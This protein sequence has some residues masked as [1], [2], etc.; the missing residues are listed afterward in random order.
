MVNNARKL[1]NPFSTGGGGSHFEA[2]VQAAFVALMLAGGF[3]PCL[4]NWPISK[5][6]LQGKFAGYE[7][8]DLVVFTEMAGS[9]Q[10]CKMLA[11]IKHSIHVTENDKVFGEVIQAAWSDF[12]NPRLFTRDKDVIALITGPLS[13]TDIQDVRTILEWARHSDSAEEFIEKVDLANFSSQSKR[14][15]LQAFRI[16]LQNANSGTPVSN[17]VLFEFLKHFYLLGYDLDV[18]SGVT[19]S[20][21]HSLIGQYAVENVAALWTQLVDEVQSAN[22]NAGT[23][24]RESLPEALRDM[25]ALPTY[26]V[27]PDDFSIVQPP[28]TKPDWNQSQYAAALASTNLIGAWSEDSDADRDVIFHITNED[29]DEWVLKIR[30]ILQQPDSPLSL[31]EQKWHIVDRLELWQALGSRL[32]DQNLDNF[33]DVAVSTLRERDPQFDLPT[34]ERYMALVRGKALAHSLELRQGMAETLAILANEND[35]LVHCSPNK[36][37]NIARSAVREIFEEADWI[38]WGSLDALLSTLAEAAPNEFLDAVDHALQQSPCPFDELFAQ[39]DSGIMGRNYLTGLLW[40]LEALAWEETYLVR[41]CVILGELATHDPGGNWGNRP[42]TSLT[43]ILLPWLPQTTSSFDRRKAAVQALI[44]EFP[45]AAWRLLLSLLPN[46]HQTSFYT[47]KPSWRH[48]IP[49]DWRDGVTGQE[50]WQQVDFYAEQAVLLAT[51]SLDKLDEL[52]KH[53]ENLPHTSLDLALDYLSSQTIVDLPEDRRLPLWANLMEV[54]GRHRQF[55]TADWAMSSDTVS[56][57]EDVADRLAPINPLNLHRRLFG[58]REFDLYEKNVNLE[59][60]QRKLAERRVQ[61]VQD[62]LEYGGIDAVTHFV[63]SVESPHLVGYSL[64]QLADNELDD[65]LLPGLLE[66]ANRSLQHFIGGYVWSRHLSQGWD[67][68]DGLNKSQWSIKQISEFLSY[69]PFTGETWTRATAWLGDSEAEYWSKAVVNPY[70]ADCDLTLAIDKLIQYARPRAAIACLYSSIHNH[71]PLDQ[72][73]S[74]EA[75][76]AVLSS[77]ESLPTLDSYHIT[78]ILKALQDDPTTDP[79]GLLWLEWAYLPLLDK[80]RSTAPKLLETRLASNP[81]F[82]CDILKLLYRSKKEKTPKHEPSEPDKAVARNAWQ[83]LN[84]WQTPPGLQP[85]GQFSTE[86]FTQWLEQ[87][88]EICTESGH[89][90]VALN[91]VGQILIHCPPDP[92]GLWIHRTAAD[93]LNGRNADRMRDG[94]SLALYSSRGVHKVVPTGQPERELAQRNRD[95]ADEVENAGYQR[96]A[97]TLRSLAESYDRQAERIIAEH[98]T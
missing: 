76:K 24:S 70:Q 61:A 73:R 36:P 42:I 96:L 30:E 28:K 68:A 66:N 39:E 77:T 3:V 97:S 22:K 18:K 20:L 16:Q 26:A 93:A 43:T 23:I 56:R 48:I 98:D 60:Q 15:K 41:V 75:L 44:R 84:V 1:S 19:L 82:F 38:L 29:Y 59:E 81:T 83:L 50:Y 74:I 14:N 63:D 95:R 37:E 13:S 25:F 31:K 71:Q 90:E 34:V 79:D 27:I 85:D 6:K 87:V 65:V 33:K 91:H 57:I 88:R 72:A 32:F 45:E 10:K 80:N 49:K 7:T 69:L 21:L 5:I 94:F 2:H 12:N 47:N 35:K 67:W 58:S 51:Q 92:D 9:G 62:I 17:D 11:Q 40:A 54:I 64:S 52:I 8:D 86:Q 55:S 4:P 46:Q 78:E 89:L 53:L